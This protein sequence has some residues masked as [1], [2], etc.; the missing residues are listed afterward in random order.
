MKLEGKIEG[1]EIMAEQ[2]KKA[3]ITLLTQDK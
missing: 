3:I 2:S 1:M